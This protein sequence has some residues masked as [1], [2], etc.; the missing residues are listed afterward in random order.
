MCIKGDER[1]GW[2]EVVSDDRGAT[3]R[4]GVSID[5]STQVGRLP[6]GKVVRYINKD[7][8]ENPK[9]YQFCDSVTR[10]Y[11]EA[12]SSSPAGWLSERGRYSNHPY[13]I[14]TQ[15]KQ[16][17]SDTPPILYN[18]QIRL[19][20]DANLEKRAKHLL[21]ERKRQA[22]LSE[23]F[24]LLQKFNEVVISSIP[25]IDLSLRGH[26][27]SLCELLSKCRQLL[28]SDLKLE[29]WEKA[30]EETQVLAMN[31]FE[32]KLSRSLA[33][34][35]K[36]RG[37]PDIEATSSLFG[38][39]FRQ[40]SSMAPSC[41][42]VRLGS[43][44]YN[45]VFKGEMAHDAGGPYRETFT[46]Y[47]EELQSSSLTLLIKCP[48]AANGVGINRD[49]WIPN[50]NA[51]SPLEIEMFEF[52]GRLMGLSIRT[53]LCFELNLPSIIWKQ[54]VGQEL[55]KEDLEGIDL[56][57][58]K[59]M[60]SVRSI[61]EKGI[62]ADIFQD[63]IFET[64]TTYSSDNRQ[65]E[66][67]PKG[68]SLAVTFDN[69]YE[70][71]SLVEK[72]RLQEFSAQVNALKSG[73]SQVVPSSLLTLF[74][75]DELETFVCGYPDIDISLLK[76]VTEYNNCSQS[77]IHIVNFWKVFE[78]FTAEEKS[79]FIRFTWGRSR[80]PTRAEY[81]HQKFKLQSFSKEPADDY[82]PVAH[83]C[84]FSLELPA[85]SSKDIM[86]R[87]LQYAIYNCQAIDADDTTI[88]RNAASLG[89]DI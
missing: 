3:L 11:V 50:P 39:A 49:K 55:N 17:I 36:M 61:D 67:K 35:H 16:P 41:Y 31:S 82:L 69:R 1:K 48:N 20:L 87:K 72:Y 70:Y 84:F 18:F 80:L 68:A 53:R 71:A 64:F 10:F 44:L 73:L 32:L 60:E 27:W 88:G 25:F 22:F 62:T 65:V 2:L 74:T 79:L 5:D 19:T 51:T 66:L 33:A 89:W 28:F 12:T 75:W 30:L 23:R 59:S 37:I 34:K 57:C 38:Q 13:P 8:Y 56:M 77:D 46:E 76:S 14:V 85:Y 78:E 86:R 9:M 7:A 29:I 47:M 4:S 45:T 63:V 21:Q 42:R 26:R 52:L 83:T 54:L 81:F 40:L 58:V 15:I 24:S 6:K 43:A